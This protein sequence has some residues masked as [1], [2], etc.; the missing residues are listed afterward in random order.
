MNIH[1][2]IIWNPNST[3]YYYY[4]KFFKENIKKVKFL[5]MVE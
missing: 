4:L 1:K 2:F 5:N 3:Q